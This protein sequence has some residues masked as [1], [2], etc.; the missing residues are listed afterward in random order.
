M[1]WRSHMRTTPPPNDAGL[2]RRNG[3]AR[4]AVRLRFRPVLLLG[5]FLG[6]GAVSSAKISPGDALPALAALQLEGELPN[7]E[8][9]VV[10]IDVWASWC[11]PCKASF[12]ALAEL[13]REY[14][15]RGFVVLAV[16]MDRRERD[17][18]GF[19]QRFA[20][21]FVTARDRAEKFAATFEPPA[22]PTS[23]LVDRRGRVREVHTGFHGDRTVA[24]LRAAIIA[25]LEEDI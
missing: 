12:P 24:Q 5:V 25:L 21:P 6:A 7:L 14:G 1:W 11:A 8:G 3:R 15:G 2:R 19:V 13:Q 10:L 16:S 18:A 17:Y 9:K 23:Y 20:P 4:G 22:M